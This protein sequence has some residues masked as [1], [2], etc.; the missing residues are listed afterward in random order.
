[1]K[2]SIVPSLAEPIGKI[3]KD[4]QAKY[5]KDG[6]FFISSPLSSTPLPVY[7]WIIEQ[8]DTRINLLMLAIGAKGNYANVMPGTSEE[9]GWHIAHLITEFRQAHTQAGSQSYEGAH[10]RE[11]GMSLSPQQVINAEKVAV[12]I[13]G[14]KKRE[15]TKELLSYS[16]FNPQFPLSI[17]YHPSVRDRVEMYI[18][19]D[20]GAI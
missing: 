1:M 6:L 4:L 13:S 3:W 18:T 10:F 9:T 7:E 17:I 16:A 8:F 14:E 2:K 11:Y 19:E 5:T 20:V 12:I 15:L